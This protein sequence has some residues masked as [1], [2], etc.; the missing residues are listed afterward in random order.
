MTRLDRLGEAALI[1]SLLP[2]LAHDGLVIGPGADDAAVWSEPGG[3]FTVASCDASVEGVHFDLGWMAPE[4]VG[5]QALTLA[6]GDLAA[7]G[8]E[9]TFGLVALAAPGD[10][11]SER[12]LGIYSG[13]AELAATVGLRLAGGDTTSTPGPAMLALTVL[14]TTQ[15]APL[16]RA[17]AKAGWT[18]AV[19][20]PLGG[21]AL[22]LAAQRFQRRLPKLAEGRHLNE[23]GLACG[24]V[25][26]GLLRELEKF[27]AASG[28]G[29][30]VDI[31][32]VPR[33][34]GATPAQALASGEEVEL[35]CIG[36]PEVIAAT[37]LLPF[38][39][40]TSDGRVRV[41]DKGGREV[42]VAD[43]GHEHFR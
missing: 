17:G 6:L 28:V 18:A 13:L 11:D 42:T 25:S 36:P 1:K 27:A 34:E 2:H 7:K 12:V 5:W 15:R 14:G 38:G 29:C 31:E 24:D 26:D 9:P 33:A 10:W 40:L 8:A 39:T 4:E 23:A 3:G 16:A 35:V 20:G 37:G 22:A 30:V 43:R 19:T 21:A 41:V 32:A